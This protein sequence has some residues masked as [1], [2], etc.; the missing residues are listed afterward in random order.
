MWQADKIGSETAMW[1]ML[2]LVATGHFVF[3]VFCQHVAVFSAF[4]GGIVLW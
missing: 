4:L 2:S 3:H 1:A